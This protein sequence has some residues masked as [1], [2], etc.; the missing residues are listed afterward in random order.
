[1]KTIRAKVRFILIISLTGSILLSIFNIISNSIQNNA[2]KEQILLYD[3]VGASK[4]IKYNMAV[5]RKFEQQYLR[6]PMQVT[7]D[8]AIRNNSQI[9]TKSKELAKKYKDYPELSVQFKKIEESASSYR[10]QYI[11]L[12]KMYQEIGYNQ[13]QGLKGEIAEAENAILAYFAKNKDGQLSNQFAEITMYEKQY[14]ATKDED[15]YK[16]FLLLSSSFEQNVSESKLNQDQKK[17]LLALFD[18]FHNSTKIMVANYYITDDY[19]ESFDK[20]GTAIEKAALEV[21]QK[22]GEAQ[23]ELTKSLNNQSR[24]MFISSMLISFLLVAVLLSIGIFLIRAISAS[25]ASLKSGAEKIGSGDLTHRVKKVTNDEMGELAHTFNQMA[26]KVLISLTDVMH[27]ADKLNSSSQ[28]LAAISEETSAQSNEVNQAIR[29]VAI[30][31]SSQTT[32]LEE[33]NTI[34][35][36][37]TVSINESEK[38]TH[39]IALEAKRTELEGQ[40]GLDVIQSLQLTSD[41]F[42]ELANHLTLQIQNASKQ[43]QEI[44][45]IVGTIQEIAENTN[46]LALNAAIESAR[47]GEAGRSFAVVA[48]EV[49]KLAERSKSEAQNIQKVIKNMNGQMAKLMY[50]AEKFNEYKE[51]QSTSV[52]LTKNAF[53]NIVQNVSSINTKIS[54]VQQSITGIQSSNNIL[55][56]QMETVYEISE[57]SAAASEEVSASSETQLLAI[58]QVNEAASALSNIASGLQAIVSQFQLEGIDLNQD[59]ITPSEKGTDRKREYNIF[60]KVKLKKLVKKIPSLSKRKKS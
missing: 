54:A 22:V 12:I 32:Q 29:Q 13:N 2:K 51:K 18:T 20:A 60:S 44:S 25:I 9:R 40:S 7:A 17:S 28:N 8:I 1:M 38:L 46:L 59:K 11:T 10:E 55:S 57:Q 23:Q 4:D 37:V 19:I 27:S 56:E 58:S 52:D 47:A 14:L 5:T 31:A 21:D 26:E 33:S 16:Q 49:R 30:G 43:S 6:E 39:D 42:L 48:S 50:E 45:S 3:A 36:N 34:I 15:L 41:Q 35:K 24:F 53:G